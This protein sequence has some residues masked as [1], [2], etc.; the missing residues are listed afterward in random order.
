MLNINDRAKIDEIARNIASENKSDPFIF[1][2][3]R[4]RLLK[5]GW[6]DEFLRNEIKLGDLI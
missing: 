4:A 3:V 6:F 1:G 5:P 2:R